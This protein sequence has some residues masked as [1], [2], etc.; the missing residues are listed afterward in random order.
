MWLLYVCM[1]NMVLSYAT[2]TTDLPLFE[3]MQDAREK[4]YPG[5]HRLESDSDE[6]CSACSHCHEVHHQRMTCPRL[7][8]HE[9]H[10]C[11]LEPLDQSSETQD[12][13]TITEAENEETTISTD[14][15]W[16]VYVL[17]SFLV[18]P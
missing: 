6:S 8:V 4:Q 12:A 1:H 17:H 2:P 5:W 9:H 14:I 3:S 18:D 11:H 13:F 7:V 16:S 15:P 10:S